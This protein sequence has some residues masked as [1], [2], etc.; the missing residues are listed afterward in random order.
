MKNNV[1]RVFFSLKEEK[2]KNLRKKNNCTYKHTATLISS[3]ISFSFN[4]LVLVHVFDDDVKSCYVRCSKF[5]KILTGCN[6]PF[7]KIIE[8]LS[9]WLISI[10]TTHNITQEIEIV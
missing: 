2:K 6:F 4:N 9:L 7:K 8:S 1:V 3:F 10:E 5:F